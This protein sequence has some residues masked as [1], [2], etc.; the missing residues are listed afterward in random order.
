VSA[1]YI[2]RLVASDASSSFRCLQPEAAHLQRL[3]TKAGNLSPVLYLINRQCRD[4]GLLVVGGVLHWSA[5]PPPDSGVPVHVSVLPLS[6]PPHPPS[7]V[8]VPRPK[9]SGS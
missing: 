6:L 9:H 8:R 3:P 2:Q 7:V 5:E 4:S 1:S